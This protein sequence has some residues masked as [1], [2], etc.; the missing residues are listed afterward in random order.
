MNHKLLIGLFKKIDTLEE[1]C[2][3]VFGEGA[4]SIEEMEKSISEGF[5]PDNLVFGAFNTETKEEW[6]F[7]HLE[8]ISDN[9]YRVSSDMPHT[10]INDIIAKDENEAIIAVE[11][12]LKELIQ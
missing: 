3:A 12:I 8:M 9:Q 6:E 5:S 4:C 2:L 1:K 10:G 11:K 7:A